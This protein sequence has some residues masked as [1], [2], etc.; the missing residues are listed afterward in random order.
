MPVNNKLPD[1]P[2]LVNL[3][4]GEKPKTKFINNLDAVDVKLINCPDVYELM[5]YIPEFTSG[6]WEDKPKT[7]FAVEEREK[8]IVDLFDGYLLPTAL[9]TIKITFI[10][11]GIDLAD[12]C[13]LIR[14]RTMSFSASGTGDRD[15]RHDDV[16][17]KPSIIGSEYEERYKKLL[18]DSKQLYSDVMDDPDMP[19]LDARTFMPRCTDNYYYVSTD[20]K[21][22][23]SFIK[24]RKDESIE[25]ES[26]NVF[27]L[28]LW[29]E[30]CKKFPMLKNHIDLS[31]PDY[32]AVETSI[33]GR[34]SNFYRPEPKNDF[35]EYKLSWFMRQKMR[36]QMN[37]GDQYIKI[38]DDILDQIEA[39]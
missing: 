29:L 8:A 24:Q 20:M 23:F 14:H 19:I 5:S 39:L 22:I 34:S 9:E 3:K 13:H 38:R 16:L 33:G 10:V 25:P 28:K 18:E 21:G 1:H 31:S 6:T 4:T 37:G 7:D 27:A 12:V 35:Y 32:F 15:M 30:V 36:S 2:L 11:K 17:I 26:M